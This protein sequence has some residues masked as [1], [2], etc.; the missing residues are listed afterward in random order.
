MYFIII[1]EFI[2]PNE[3]T[4]PAGLT[5]LSGSDAIGGCPQDCVNNVNKVCQCSDGTP[6]TSTLIDGVC[7]TSVNTTEP[8]WARDFFTISRSVETQVIIGF[9]WNTGFALRG[10]EL[11][12][13]NCAT[14]NTD[15]HT[16][17]VW[18]SIIYPTF[19]PTSLVGSY[20]ANGDDLNC[21][22]VTT[23]II[24]ANANANFRAYYIEFKF[25][26]GDSNTGIYI[27]EAKFSDT[28]ITIPNEATSS[29][30]S[31][32]VTSTPQQPSPSSTITSVPLPMMS[33]IDSTL[34]SSPV[35]TV[36]TAPIQNTSSSYRLSTMQL[37]ATPTPTVTRVGF[38]DFST[39]PPTDTV[40]PTTAPPPG[41]QLGAIV[42]PLV[43][44]IVVL[45]IVIVI[46][47]LWKQKRNAERNR[48]EGIIQM[49]DLTY[50]SSAIDSENI[51]LK[52]NQAYGNIEH[53]ETAVTVANLV[54]NPSYES[55]PP[56]IAQQSVE[57]DY[58]PDL[59]HG[60]TPAS[61]SRDGT[62]DSNGRPTSVVYEEIPA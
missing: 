33:S 21:N 13:F 41:P 38:T 26:Q 14:L 4:L 31:P 57:Y 3:H 29:P 58:I 12:L 43:G 39:D 19:D 32:A 10:V 2:R 47:L 59:L 51:D 25:L 53:G 20:V 56:P 49:N 44:V 9:N 16:I 60:N 62:E 1:G 48:P 55:M 45:I 36:T 5:S 17:N 61:N 35:V 6:F 50:R 22:S 18:G 11:K 8:T 24:Q 42:G 34:F 23:I 46:V 37:T 28:T 27:A 40:P 15:I 7:P 52:T 30:P 54:A